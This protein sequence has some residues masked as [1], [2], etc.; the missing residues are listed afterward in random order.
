MTP[1]QE[2]ALAIAAARKR[3]AES[4]PDGTDPRLNVR[5][6]LVEPK[7]RIGETL[8]NAG[9]ELGGAL[10]RGTTGLVDIP[11]DINTIGSLVGHNPNLPTLTEAV[12]NTTGIGKHGFMEPG[13][14]RDVVQGFGVTAP[15][16]LTVLKQAPAMA[17]REVD[18]ALALV[19]PVDMK[20]AARLS[21][22]A[23]TAVSNGVDEKA[24]DLVRSASPEGKSHMRDMVMRMRRFLRDPR[25]SGR[26]ADIAGEVVQE[27][28]GLISRTRQRLGR[29]L[30]IEVNK[31]G[32]KPVDVTPAYNDFFAALRDEGVV[33]DGFSPNFSG[34]S[35]EQIGATEKLL[36]DVLK[37]IESVEPN[38]LQLHRLKRYLDKLV[39]TGKQA[40]GG[41]DGDAV[42]IVK[43]LRHGVDQTLDNTFPSYKAI[44]DEL[45]TVIQTM[46]QVNDAMPR[47]VDLD[48]P[49]SAA[50]LGQEA[51]KLMSNYASRQLLANSFDQI[52]EVAAKYG[53]NVNSSV[54]DLAVF[55]KHLDESFEPVAK[56][57]FRAEV[58]QGASAAARGEGQ[59]WFLGRMAERF[60]GPDKEEALS[61]LEEL[62]RESP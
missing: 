43:A 27:R 41:V 6:Q 23:K 52:D 21:R 40:E 55:A 33:L 58:T 32:P 17:A 38:A 7:P 28:L 48:A 44:N 13:L 51:R 31:I 53:A 22:A 62:L 36:K 59:N 5:G 56:T 30:D 26:P 34:S 46:N 1:E 19:K 45:S 49:G 18:N 15:G 25:Y 35:F 14:G 4:L 3:K 8:Y 20:Q 16:A 61:A 24:V 9:A 50:A 54:R 60:F 57:G 42:R 10:A 29:S 11:Q 37:R 47:K 2:K 39:F 12:Q